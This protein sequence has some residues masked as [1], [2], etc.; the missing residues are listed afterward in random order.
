[1]STLS[2]GANDRI[3]SETHYF[4]YSEKILKFYE[5]L[6]NYLPIFPKSIEFIALFSLKFE[7]VLQLPH[8]TK[9]RQTMRRDHL[10]FL[11]N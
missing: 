11:K 10:K 7:R 9:R 3:M 2:V 1:M 4:E 6:Q 5:Q 8:V